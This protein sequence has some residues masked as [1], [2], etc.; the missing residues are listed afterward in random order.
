MDENPEKRTSDSKVLESITTMSG[1][2]VRAR[3]MCERLRKLLDEGAYKL[4][5]VLNI[6]HGMKSREQ[7]IVN[8]GGDLAVMQQMNEEQIDS[9]LEMLKSPAFQSLA[10]QMLVKWAAGMENPMGKNPP[11]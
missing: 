11:V 10:R 1:E 8:A 6:I 5:A 3:E 7:N 2:V 4:D 9:L